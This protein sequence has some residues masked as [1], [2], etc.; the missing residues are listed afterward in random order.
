MNT[1]ITIALD[2]RRARKDGSFPIVLRLSHFRKTS[3]IQTGYYVQ[4]SDWDEKNRKIKKSYRGTESVS[5]LN[6]YLD[7]K[8]AAALDIITKLDE[9]DVLSS[10]S[11]VQLKG[12]IKPQQNSK[13]FFGYTKTLIA[14][15][16]KANRIGNADAYAAVA[17]VVKRYVGEKDLL[18]RQINLKFLQDF[19]IH[20]LSKGNGWNSLAMY[21]KTIRAI[22]NRAIK[23]GIIDAGHYPFKDYSIKTT[24]T[25]KRAINTAALKKIFSLE[26]APTHPLRF[27]KDMFQVSFNLMGMPFKDIALLRLEN[28]VDGRVKYQRSKT[29]QEYDIKINAALSDIFNDYT[30]NKSPEDF[31]FSIVKRDNLDDQHKDIK[32]ARKRYNKKLKELGKLCG[33]EENLTSY[34]SRHSFAS[35]ANNK[36]VPVTAISEMLG[37]Q[38]LKT[39]QIYLN[40]LSSD[41]V[42]K[43]NDDITTL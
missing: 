9:D 3:S 11:V 23:A 24:K 33:I 26:L 13:S 27:A 32:W 16:R 19:E 12:K 43:L 5:R 17:G 31:V 42:D 28:I 1:S 21:M 10:L 35:L 40:G 8:K 14:E 30:K 29:H 15:L 6:N 41:A 34:V 22:Y 4:K 2:T 37:H 18:F 7:K 39:T 38:N 25:K 36:G 20:H